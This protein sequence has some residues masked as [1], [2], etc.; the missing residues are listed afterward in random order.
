[1]ERK[2]RNDLHRWTVHSTCVGCGYTIRATSVADTSVSATAIVNVTG[3]AAVLEPFYD[4]QHPYVQV[5][6][7]MPYA[8]YFAPGTIRIWAHAPDTGNDSVNGYSPQVDF[9][10]GTTMVGSVHIGTN[11]PIDYY[12]VDVTGIAA[13]SYEVFVRSRLASGTVESIH[14][15]ITV[16][17]LPPHTGPSEPLHSGGLSIPDRA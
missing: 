9:Y 5:M 3:G 15:P 7:P 17:D 1:M 6:T 13:G 8:T 14:V 4:A 12:E 16:V 10:L 11:D 2:R